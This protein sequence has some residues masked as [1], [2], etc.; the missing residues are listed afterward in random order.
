MRNEFLD[1]IQNI[2]FYYEAI[3]CLSGTINSQKCRYWANENPH[4]MQEVHAENP[5]QIV[6]TEIAGVK[7]LLHL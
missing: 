6:W 5:Q 1:L 4:W 2:A 7:T 3:F